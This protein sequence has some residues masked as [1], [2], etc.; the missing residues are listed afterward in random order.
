MKKLILL[1]MV[2]MW[3]VLNISALTWGGVELNK[4]YVFDTESKPK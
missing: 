2:S 1:I 3:L 4:W